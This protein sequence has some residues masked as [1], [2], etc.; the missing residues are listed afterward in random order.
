MA[1]AGSSDDTTTED[2][3]DSTGV[4]RQPEPPVPI[5]V[6]HHSIEL[7]WG[8]HTDHQATPATGTNRPCY[9]IE[10]EDCSKGTKGEFVTVYR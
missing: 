2:T 3:T 10:M 4:P 5:K 7:T 9:T 6:N 8:H 1:D